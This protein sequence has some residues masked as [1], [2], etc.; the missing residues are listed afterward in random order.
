VKSL[1]SQISGFRI[2]IDGQPKR[3]LTPLQQLSEVLTIMGQ[4]REVEEKV[5]EHYTSTVFVE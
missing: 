1:G 3:F 4:P 5:D 2:L